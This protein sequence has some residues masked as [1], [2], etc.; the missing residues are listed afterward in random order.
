M[1]TVSENRSKTPR[2]PKSPVRRFIERAFFWIGVIAT[3]Y[4]AWDG[5]DHILEFAR[6]RAHESLLQQPLVTSSRVVRVGSSGPIAEKIL[7]A[8]R[9]EVEPSTVTV[10]HDSIWIAN[11]VTF[12][13]GATIQTAHITIV[14]KV[15]SG[16]HINVS[17]TSARSPAQ[18][19]AAG[20]RLLILAGHVNN[21][22]FEARGGEGAPGAPGGNGSDGQ[23]G[24]CDGFGGY[25]GADPGQPGGNGQPGG[26][27]APGGLIRVA[28]IEP[29]SAPDPNLYGAGRGGPG[30]AAGH[31]GRG[32]SGCVGLGGSQPSQPNG[33]D[34]NP[35]PDNHESV[36]SGR[37]EFTRIEYSRLRDIAQSP[38]DMHEAVESVERLLFH[39]DSKQ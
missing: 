36:E 12:R 39:D 23:K 4:G 27:G 24:K 26:P 30:G 15:L 22:V 14:T 11:E 19:P 8:D 35:G 28:A 1:N 31:G 34:G 29:V 20:G 38:G 7:I 2:H 5:I 32:G 21:V 9:I 18:V 13:T 37:Y 6:H 10:P 3:L 33:L 25:R 17:G 16:G